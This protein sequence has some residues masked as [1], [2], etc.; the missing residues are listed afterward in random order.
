MTTD[1]WAQL[2]QVGFAT[3]D[4]DADCA[5]ATELLGL[6]PSFDDPLLEEMGLRDFTAP[7]GPETYV[8]VLGPIGTD[9][10]VARWLAGR[11]GS[12]GWVLSVQV[13]DLVGVRERA[14]AEGV[15]L[16]MDT[17]AMGHEV[18]QLHPRDAG[19]LLELDAFMP[20]D[21]WFWD[22]METAKAAQAARGVL[23]DGITAVDVAAEDPVALAGVWARI[24]GLPEPVVDGAGAGAGAGGGAGATLDFSG[25]A[26]RFVPAD[27]R[28]G[29]VGMDVSLTDRSAVGTRADG[30][31]CLSTVR[32]V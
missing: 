25:R 1:R 15:R 8:E 14:A 24:I 18:I 28:T 6:G 17:E 32:F 26:I 23:A 22:D 21:A 12:S 9:H 7:I 13:P 5:H 10:S 19:V 20:A 3:L 4:F 2:R 11:G 31:L 16:A 27:G 29:L 30:Q